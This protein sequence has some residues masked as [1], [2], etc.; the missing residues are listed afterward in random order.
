MSP[1]ER[2]G[3]AEVKVARAPALLVAYGLGS[4]LGIALYDPQ[5]QVGGLAHTLLP[6][7]RPRQRGAGGTKFVETAIR[8]MVDE[9]LQ[10]GACRERLAAKVVGGAN[11]FEPLHPAVTDG[12]GARNAQTA[13]ETLRVLGI[14]LLAEDVGGNHGRTVEFV[15]ATGEV[16]VRSVCHA[17]VKKSL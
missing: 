14:P 6:A 5:L 16:R 13:R 7:P 17:D 8:V 3:I 12:I 10:R 9:L 11:M 1:R 15:L 4:C 2:V